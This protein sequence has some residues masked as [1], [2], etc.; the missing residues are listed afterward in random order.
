MQGPRQYPDRAHPGEIPSVSECGRPIAHV[1]HDLVLPPETLRKRVRAD[2]DQGVRPHLPMSQERE[3]VKRL[4]RENFALRRAND[5]RG[6]FRFVGISCRN[7]RLCHGAGRTARRL[8][9][10]GHCSVR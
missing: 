10:D 3:E 1:A 6:G 9:W 7:R 5:I 4:N 8:R 2:A